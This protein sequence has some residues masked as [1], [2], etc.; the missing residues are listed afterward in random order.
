M[1]LTILYT[2]FLVLMSWDLRRATPI[3]F[4]TW[5]LKCAIREIWK[6]PCTQGRF[7]YLPTIQHYFPT[8]HMYWQGTN[9]MCVKLICLTSLSV[10]SSKL[11]L[12]LF[13]SFL[14]LSQ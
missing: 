14:S 2:T 9:P 5:V 7:Q 3:S 1:F 13:Q 8:H 4:N 12:V 11:S 10:V 6:K